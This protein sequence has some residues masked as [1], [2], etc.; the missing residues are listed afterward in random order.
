MG[1]EQ[2]QPYLS[3]HGEMS[4]IERPFRQLGCLRGPFP[5]QLLPLPVYHTYRQIQPYSI[6]LDL[7]PHGPS[8][9]GSKPLD[10]T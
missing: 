9:Q 7:A 5:L 3:H 2:C 4:P 6:D 8:V 1:L 10:R